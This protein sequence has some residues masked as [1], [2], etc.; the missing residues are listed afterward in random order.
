LDCC[1]DR[2]HAE[3]LGVHNRKFKGGLRLRQPTASSI[4]ETTK[5]R[6]EKLSKPN[7]FYFQLYLHLD[8]KKTFRFFDKKHLLLQRALKILLLFIA[9]TVPA[10]GQKPARLVRRNQTNS[11]R[12]VSFNLLDKREVILQNIDSHLRLRITKD[13]S[14]GWDVAV[15]HKPDHADS[16]LNLLYQSLAWHGPP[17]IAN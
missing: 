14:A 1:R 13:G 7:R 5:P 2:N 3:S 16:S 12:M 9:L 8:L 6:P 4:D 10:M 15:V 11:T 17:S